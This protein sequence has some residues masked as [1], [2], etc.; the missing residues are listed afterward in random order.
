MAFFGHCSNKEDIP[1][2][3]MAERK[4]ML[5]LAQ[6]K[7]DEINRGTFGPRAGASY[8]R[9]GSVQ[10]KRMTTSHD[11]N[12]RNCSITSH[13][14][15]T[16][17]YMSLMIHKVEDMKAMLQEEDIALY[18]EWRSLFETLHTPEFHARERVIQ[19]KRVKSTFDRKRKYKDEAVD[20]HNRLTE[21]SRDLK[22]LQK[23]SNETSQQLSKSINV[24]QD[25]Q[26]GLTKQVEKKQY[27]VDDLNE[28]ISA[29]KMELERKNATILSL[30]DDSK[31]KDDV[32]EQT[33]AKLQSKEGELEQLQSELSRTRQDLAVSN[34]RAANALVT[35]ENIER[36]F[37][38]HRIEQESALEK[39]Q[40]ELTQMESRNATISTQLATTKDLLDEAR[41]ELDS[42]TNEKELKLDD[43]INESRGSFKELKTDTVAL[44]ELLSSDIRES[45]SA[46]D[47][48]VS[49]TQSLVNEAT[50]Q[51]KQSKEET[52]QWI[53]KNQNTLD[54]TTEM[55]TKLA[56]ENDAL[57]KAISNE[58][59]IH[60]SLTALEKGSSQIQLD[61]SKSYHQLVDLKSNVAALIEGEKD[62]RLDELIAKVS[63][64]TTYQ[65]DAL[66]AVLSNEKSSQKSLSSL[67]KGYSE[68]HLEVSKF[69][70]RFDDLMSK[71]SDLASE[72][73]R[74][75]PG[76][77]DLLDKVSVLAA[78]GSTSLNKAISSEKYLSN[79]EKGSSQINL[80][81]SKSHERL[82]E[83]MNK[84]SELA[85]EA[86]RNDPRLEELLAKVSEFAENGNHALS[87]AISNEKYLSNLEKGSKQIQLEASKSRDRLDELVGMV[88]DLTGAG[89]DPRLDKIILQVSEEDNRSAAEESH[90]NINNAVMGTFS[91]DF[92]EKID[93]KVTTR[94]EAQHHND[95][96]KKVLIVE[97]K[98]SVAMSSTDTFPAEGISSS[99]EP[100]TVN[101]M[102]Q[103]VMNEAMSSIT[104]R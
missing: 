12:G 50:E 93:E 6:Q 51:Q 58:K 28:K 65:N 40:R 43:F 104:P 48:R 64:L 54:I 30:G 24:L 89:K 60:E 84:V 56:E 52:M 70:E 7:L 25:E 42:Y 44:K 75:D 20:L 57:K 61:I 3:K 91:D 13:I 80:Q 8:G 88:A 74:R 4:D 36:K 71:V 21:T 35:L 83:L 18:N 87:K 77:D 29:L 72:A 46:L 39:L 97:A 32:F 16:L 59:K 73:R 85:G 92:D 37:A 23:L 19:N 67:E 82:D 96:P 68:I 1:S 66:K 5:I 15:S 98:D 38:T 78:D 69:H 17:L 31:K 47:E 94:E 76:L 81:V 49:Q 27:E 100:S 33:R 45:I 41:R 101:D 26:A 9:P 103:N 11:S 53:Q 14:F 90:S 55:C 86:K 99:G 79:L 95:G 63:S 2:S 102:V 22:H 34:E 10:S 62:P